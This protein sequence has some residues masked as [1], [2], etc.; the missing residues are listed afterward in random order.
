MPNIPKYD[1]NHNGLQKIELSSQMQEVPNDTFTQEQ[2]ETRNDTEVLL[3]KESEAQNIKEMLKVANLPEDTSVFTY[4]NNANNAHELISRLKDTVEDTKDD[5]VSV[6]YSD[7]T[8]ALIMDNDQFGTVVNKTIEERE[9]VPE[10]IHLARITI[11][12]LGFTQN[13]TIKKIQEKINNM[14]GLELC[15]IED[16]IVRHIED[17]DLPRGAY[18]YFMMNQFT[19]ADGSPRVFDRNHNDGRRFL[20]ARWAG[21]DDQWFLVHRVIVRLSKSES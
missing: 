15:R 1:I 6:T 10:T 11:K 14:P 18:E 4:V 13:P 16:A 20:S 5:D 12:D 2:K 21:P 19:G 8:K 3:N 9:G 17:K 7:Y